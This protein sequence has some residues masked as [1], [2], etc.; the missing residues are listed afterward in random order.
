MRKIFLSYRDCLGIR[1]LAKND[2]P[3]ENEQ[4]KFARRLHEAFERSHLNTSPT[5]RRLILPLRIVESTL[6]SPL[7]SV[8]AKATNLWWDNLTSISC[9]S[10]KKLTQEDEMVLFYILIILKDL[11]LSGNSD[12]WPSGDKALKCLLKDKPPEAASVVEKYFRE[13]RLLEAD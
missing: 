9:S 3:T 13:D 5:G 4:R 2:K 12:W 10:K 8:H 1:S 11:C 6:Q 7:S